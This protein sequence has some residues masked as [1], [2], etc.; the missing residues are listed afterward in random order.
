MS[1]HLARISH[2]GIR[3]AAQRTAEA[4]RHAAAAR[5]CEPQT[6]PPPPQMFENAALTFHQSGGRYVR[7]AEALARQRANKAASDAHARGEDV[8]HPLLRLRL[9]GHPPPL[10]A[11]PEPP[12]RAV[13][14][15]KK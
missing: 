7:I 5:A 4:M 6:P 1:D 14:H 2:P 12:K 8:G 11:L 13:K 15:K 9:A 10:P 3:E